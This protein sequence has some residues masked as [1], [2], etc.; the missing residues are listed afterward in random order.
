LLID[1]KNRGKLESCFQEIKARDTNIIIFSDYE[2]IEDEIDLDKKYIVKLPNMEHYEEIIFTVG[3]QLF[4]Y[5][6]SINQ[7]IN[8]DKPRNLAKVVTVE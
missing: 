6:L 1:S 3:L 7:N 2:N 8:P 5:F 4:C